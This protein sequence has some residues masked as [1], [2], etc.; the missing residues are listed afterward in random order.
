MNGKKHPMHNS[1]IQN[2]QEN[3]QNEIIKNV[4]SIDKSQKTVEDMTSPIEK[5]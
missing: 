3:D 4:H 2:S 1:Y 5:K